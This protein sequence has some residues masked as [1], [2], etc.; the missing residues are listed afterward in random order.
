[1]SIDISF[2]AWVCD[3]DE[4]LTNFLISFAV[5]D[6]NNNKKQRISRP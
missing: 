1:M 2:D 3:I 4:L 5:A 6:N